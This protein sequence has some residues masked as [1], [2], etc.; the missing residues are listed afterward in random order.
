VEREYTL[1]QYD[2]KVSGAVTLLLRLQHRGAAVDDWVELGMGSTQSEAPTPQSRSGGFMRLGRGAAE[3]MSLEGPDALDCRMEAHSRN[4]AVTPATGSNAHRNQKQRQGSVFTSSN[5]LQQGAALSRPG[6]GSES[7]SDAEARLPPTVHCSIPDSDGST[8]A[9]M[10]AAAAGGAFV[11]ASR[12]KGGSG[13]GAVTSGVLPRA[14]LAKTG[15]KKHPPCT[16]PGA[17]GFPLAMSSTGK[18]AEGSIIMAN[19]LVHAQQQASRATP[20]P[21]SQSEST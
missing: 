5:P 16:V 12:A 1:K 11:G 7:T 2:G 17:R 18:G 3:G 8:Q 10:A 19:P 13:A 20:S 4:V 21:N 9:A 15:S 14:A 6:S